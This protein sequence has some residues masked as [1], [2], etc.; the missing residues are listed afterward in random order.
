MSLAEKNEITPFIP[1]KATEE[2]SLS[3]TLRMQICVDG[4]TSPSTQQR[5][6]GSDGREGTH[7]PTVA[8]PQTTPPGQLQ[9]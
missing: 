8:R 5:T 9:V 2:K 3:V 1:L 6:A 4:L 7:C